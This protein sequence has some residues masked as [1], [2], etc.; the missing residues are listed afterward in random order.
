MTSIRARRICR[1]GSRSTAA[2]KTSTGP[3]GTRRWPNGTARGA[4]TLA[5]T[6]TTNNAESRSAKAQDG[7]EGRGRRFPAKTWRQ[8][9]S[10]HGNSLLTIDTERG[11]IAGTLVKFNDGRWTN[12]ESGDDMTGRRLLV[13]HSCRG[14]QRWENQRPVTTIIETPDK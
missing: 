6:S 9:M 2:T 11:L 8:V 4:S 7:D 12:K 14:L 13:L 10:T 1:N 5:A 3:H